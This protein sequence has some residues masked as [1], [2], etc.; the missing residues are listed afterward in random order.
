[1]GKPPDPSGVRPPSHDPSTITIAHHYKGSQTLEDVSDK[2][3]E[4]QTLDGDIATI[5]P[6]AKAGDVPIMSL[7][8]PT[9][10][11]RETE[12]T[13]TDECAAAV[14]DENNPNGIGSKNNE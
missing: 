10:P 4:Y 12:T 7:N 9:M 8:V 13:E 3:Q 11:C 2:M 5:A 1:M 6:P 14:T